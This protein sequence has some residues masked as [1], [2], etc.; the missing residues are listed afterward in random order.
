MTHLFLIFQVIALLSAPVAFANSENPSSVVWIPPAPVHFGIGSAVVPRH[1]HNSISAYA[2]LAVANRNVKL[3]LTGFTDMSGT[4][5]ANHDLS[6]RRALAVKRALLAAGVHD[7]QVSV[8]AGGAIDT[9][10]DPKESRRVD[11]DVA[12]VGPATFRSL[13]LD[14]AFRVRL[15][16]HLP[17]DSPRSL[18]LRLVP[19]NDNS[20]APLAE[21]TIAPSDERV[22]RPERRIDIADVRQ[23]LGVE[24]VGSADLIVSSSPDDDWWPVIA[25]II[26]VPHIVKRIIPE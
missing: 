22:L 8:A 5:K 4:P 17:D 19:H 10:Y 6:M 26:N 7:S 14:P 16:V 24:F 18:H 21:A 25:I 20:A 15:V 9:P 23:V 12:L 2:Q 3:A 1:A 11:I 13:P